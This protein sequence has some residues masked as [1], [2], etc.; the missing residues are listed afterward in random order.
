MREV[1]DLGAL[2][3]QLLHLIRVYHDLTP[4]WPLLPATHCTDVGFEIPLQM[5]LPVR[6]RQRVHVNE[7]G[8][9]VQAGRSV[10]VGGPV[11]V[12]HPEP[13]AQPR[14]GADH[15]KVLKLGPPRHPRVR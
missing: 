12:H 7:T 8:A 11:E 2:L 10:G 3:L 15:D 1:P 9:K 6:W 5:A 13:L 14:Q 4:M